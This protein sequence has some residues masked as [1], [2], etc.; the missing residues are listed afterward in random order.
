MVV[1]LYH[2]QIGPVAAACVEQGWVAM[3]V[4]RA[5]ATC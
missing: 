5:S 2:C 3:A 1:K 4:C